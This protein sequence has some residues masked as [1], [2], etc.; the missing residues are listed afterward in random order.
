MKRLKSFLNFGILL[1]TML[2]TMPLYAQIG[3][4]W[5]WITNATGENTQRAR[6]IACDEDDNIY[7]C[8]HF[9][10]DTTFGPGLL[11]SNGDTDAYIA[12]M[13]P[14]GEWLWAQKAGGTGSDD[15]W[16]IAVDNAGN[17]YLTG[18]F[19]STASFGTHSLV[20]AGD[21]D[22]FVAK[23]DSDGNWLWVR[24]AGS[25]GEDHGY[26][27]AMNP[28]GGCYLTGYI[29]D[30]A[31]FGDFEVSPYGYKDIFVA[32]MSADGNWQWV[33]HTGGT[34][35]DEGKALS[36][37]NDG[38][39]YLSGHFRNLAAFGEF[40]LES[41]G[42]NDV[43][44]AK[45]DSDGIWLWAEA[46]GGF[47]YYDDVWDIAVNSNNICCITG[48][49][50]SDGHFGDFTV[51]GGGAKD[52]YIAAIDSG[53]V[54]RWANSAGAGGTD[55]GNSVAIDEN[56]EVFVCGSFQNTI[57]FGDTQITS[58]GIWDIFIA[59]SDANG[60]WVWATSVGSS[61]ND[62]AGGIALNSSSDLYVHGSISG[63]AWFGDVSLDS[64]GGFDVFVALLNTQ[65]IA[66]DDPLCPQISE[67]YALMNPMPNPVFKGSPISLDT[68][69]AQKND[70][71]L[72]LYNIRGQLLQSR[73][74]NPGTQRFIFDSESLATGV[75][76]FRLKS[77]HGFSTKK[78]TVIR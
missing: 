71:E 24:S 5:A 70:G 63:T 68:H 13:N 64:S 3:P 10:G 27:I 19:E 76:L 9:L 22:I 2:S 1:A 53:G 18:I 57:G 15:A 4:Q 69:L 37:D 34:N 40:S 56:G 33:N 7:V 32:K 66:V 41:Y 8:G 29:Y 59:K 42:A 36:I 58:A 44:V 43:F 54:W 26:D 28:D 77:K 21:Y 25:S 72:E 30:T 45:L 61:T 65:G 46:C 39:I 62:F 20:S 38:N 14:D 47:S 55:T 50:Y 52:I 16:S 60:N 49:F 17:V 74:V 31:V 73:P 11:S 75:Y 6:G 67:D 23:L 35:V 12:K 51:E 48:E 78:I